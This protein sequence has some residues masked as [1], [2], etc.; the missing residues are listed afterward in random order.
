MAKAWN[1]IFDN[2]YRARLPKP[3]HIGVNTVIDK[4]MGLHEVDD[5][6]DTVGHAVDQIKFG[7]GTSVAL[8]AGLVRAKIEKMRAHDI[9]VYPG[10]TL[11]EAAIVQGVF[12][13]YVQRARDLGFTM[14][15]ISDGTIGLPQAERADMIHRALDAGLK[16]ITE[17]GKKDPRHQLAV[18]RMHAQ[19]A[20]DLALG[21]SYVVIE[22]RES[23]RGVGIYDAAGAVDQ[24]ELEA[25]VKGIEDLER[26]IWEAP[27]CTQ[28]AYLIN[29]FGANVN[30][31]NIQP[32]DVLALE[33]LRCG[34]RFETL[35]QAVTQRDGGEAANDPLTRFLAAAQTSVGA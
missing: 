26:I 32:M 8:D 12:A 10:G 25:L 27:Q 29:H 20:A 28:Q 23:G 18:G 9:D 4:Y 22:A 17:V 5:L 31:G 1:G 33:A 35:K 2:C 6:L 7:F 24:A 16:V 13:E 30:L 21:A 15:E 34:L 14:I 3:R 11:G 19:I